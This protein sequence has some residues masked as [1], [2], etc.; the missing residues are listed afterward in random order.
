MIPANYVCDVNQAK[1][2]QSRNQIDHLARQPD[3][4]QGLYPFPVSPLDDGHPSGQQSGYLPGQVSVFAGAHG[5]NTN[6]HGGSPADHRGSKSRDQ[7]S[8]ERQGNRVSANQ[9]N[10]AASQEK[11]G[12]QEVPLQMMP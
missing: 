7:P 8:D 4:I 5:H 10:K 6:P 3:R 11:G 9:S 12:K 2:M 1:N